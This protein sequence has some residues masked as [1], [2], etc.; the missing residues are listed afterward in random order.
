MLPNLFRTFKF[1]S[2][3]SDLFSSFS[4]VIENSQVSFDFVAL[5]ISECTFSTQSSLSESL[6]PLFTRRLNKKKP[7][8]TAC[9]NLPRRKNT[10]LI[11]LCSF[12]VK[13]Y[14]LDVEMKFDSKSLVTLKR[15]LKPLPGLL[16]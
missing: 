11:S 2:K 4:R 7:N 13:M 14:L 16:L 1:S 12:C 15:K 3:T 8:A 5:P 9:I 10:S 6:I